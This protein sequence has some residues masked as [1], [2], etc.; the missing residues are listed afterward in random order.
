MRRYTIVLGPSLPKAHRGA[1]SWVPSRKVSALVGVHES[2]VHGAV[3]KAGAFDTNMQGLGRCP[4]NKLHGKAWYLPTPS[5]PPPCRHPPSP[6]R[7]PVGLRVR[8]PEYPASL[9]PQSTVVSRSTGALLGPHGTATSAVAGCSGGLQR[10]DARAG[11]ATV[12]GTGAV[13]EGRVR[14]PAGRLSSGTVDGWSMT[15][16]RSSQVVNGR[17]GGYRMGGCRAARA[18]RL[19]VMARGAAT[20][21]Q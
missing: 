18:L 1:E 12:G 20:R 13:G 8:A 2:K 4:R 21:I 11:W 9:F 15:R 16:H 10:W 19:L 17:R 6:R 14:G 7:Y 3:N 5:S